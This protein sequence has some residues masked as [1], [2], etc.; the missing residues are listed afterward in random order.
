MDMEMVQYHPL[1]FQAHRAFA[2]EATLAEGAVLCDSIGQPVLPSNNAF[3]R[4][5]LSRFMVENSQ[6]G[7]E[8]GS[9]LLDMRPLGKDRIALHFPH[10][11]RV[12][13]ELASIHLDQTPLPVRPLM[14][15][16]LGGV[17]TMPDAITSLPGLFAAGSCSCSG[18]HGAHA[19]AGNM[20]L[21]SVVF[22]RR[23]GM[24]AASHAQSTKSIPSA[25]NKLQEEQQRLEELFS[26]TG[27][28]DAVVHIL[29]SLAALM[30]EHVGLVRS[31]TSLALA[32]DRLKT[33]Q[34]RYRSVG[35]RHRGKVYNTELMS[36]FE[37]G[38]L[39]D[40]AEAVIVAAQ[41]RKESRGVHYLSDFPIANNEEWCRHICVSRKNENPTF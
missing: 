21:A 38:A 25:D 7:D 15:R 27:G 9:L 18:V 19:L 16:L 17:E 24:A 11:Q 28:E 36:Y 39:L 37:L 40:V 12:A 33:L 32:A 2:S 1:G 5:Q 20:L 30:D 23:A 3:T 34:E 8:K 14:H 35:L 29:T 6:A 26:R 22:G 31:G 41:T 13:N 4:A 10:V